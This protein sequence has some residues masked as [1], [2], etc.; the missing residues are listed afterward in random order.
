MTTPLT[1]GPSRGPGELRVHPQAEVPGDCGFPRLA[2]HSEWGSG[3]RSGGSAL[4]GAVR[5]A[6]GGDGADG[7]VDAVG[8]DADGIGYVAV[9]LSGDVADAHR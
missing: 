5:L 4:V 9:G 7:F 1:A 2:P 6:R 3:A 8:G